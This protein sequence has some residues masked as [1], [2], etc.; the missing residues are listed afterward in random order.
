[1][2][3]CPLRQTF[4]YKYYGAPHLFDLYKAAEMQNIRR[5]VFGNYRDL[6]L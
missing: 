6:S 1:M 2:H 5:N 3:L 4:I